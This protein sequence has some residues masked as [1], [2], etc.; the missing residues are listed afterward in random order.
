MLMS[1]MKTY[2]MM[3]VRMKLSFEASKQRQTIQ[4]L[5]LNA[6]LKTYKERD[7]KGLI[8]KPFPFISEDTVDDLLKSSVREKVEIAMKKEAEANA[9]STY[10]MDREQY[11]GHLKT[12]M[13]STFVK[14]IVKKDAVDEIF[15]EHLE[16]DVDDEDGDGIKVDEGVKMPS[17]FDKEKLKKAMKRQ[18]D[19]NKAEKETEDEK[20]VRKL[21]NYRKKFLYKKQMKL[22]EC[23]A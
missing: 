6:I 8:E 4:E 13:V 20:K 19:Q 22:A 14:Q 23:Q 7:S 21:K 3:K 15:G 11:K 10:N 2:S 17:S 1:I 5:V 12:K 18:K 9:C 16:S